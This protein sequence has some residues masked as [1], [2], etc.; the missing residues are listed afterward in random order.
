MMDIVRVQVR[1]GEI[2]DA[3]S[4]LYVWRRASDGAVVYVGS[5]AVPPAVR[6]FL[7]LHGDPEV[8]RVR[9][10]YD[11]AMHEAFDVIAFRLPD[12]VPRSDAKEEPIRQLVDAE[13]LTDT[14]VGDLPPTPS[15][16]DGDQQSAVMPIIRHLRDA[17][18]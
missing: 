17:I 10:R 1:Q 9:H 12:H 13:M 3:G 6:T 14:Y 18:G 4:W 11:G 2:V 15:A 7:H 16:G 5:T 8:A